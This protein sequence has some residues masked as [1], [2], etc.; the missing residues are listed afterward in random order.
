MY[1]IENSKHFVKHTDESGAVYYLLSTH[2]TPQQQGFYFVNPSMD[3]EA[4][5]LWFYCSFPPASY[6]TLGVVDFTT[7]EVRH[8][9]ETMF[10]D[11]TPLVD[12]QTGYAYYAD[13]QAV[14]KHSP[15]AGSLP[16]KVCDLPSAFF[17]NDARLLNPAT[18]LTFSH[19]HKKMFLDA[20]T[21]KGWVAG[22]LTLSTG[23]FEVYC[24]PEFCR[25]HGQFNP[26]YED[27]ALM[28]EDF[29]PG[30][31]IRTDENGVF[32]RLWTVNS[33]GEEKVWPPLNLE[34]AS[35][36]WWSADG[37]K[38][39]YCKYNTDW[40]NNGVCSID[41]FTG[42]HK[43]VAPV[44]AWHGFTNTDESLIVFD[45]NNGFYR[46]CPSKVGM[47]NV[48]TGKKVYINTQN[49]PINPPESPSQYHLDPHPRYNVKDKYIVFTTAVNGH[50][51]VAVAK[52]SDIL[53]LTE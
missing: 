25:N 8:F 7:D 1:T 11:A 2:V 13:L 31:C 45:E 50:P 17:E 40:V 51:D 44:A 43:L 38:I 18:H 53:P 23:E 16:E 32:M 49:P 20:S 34:R 3:D 14:Y 33:K 22:A 30:F 5:Y 12:T 28:A 37:R 6:R 48:K 46:G 15:K 47:Y 29:A 10:S 4:R 35:H 41:I 39:Y 42:E 19:D 9:P 36:E 52:T 21:T 24:R 27:I 26:V